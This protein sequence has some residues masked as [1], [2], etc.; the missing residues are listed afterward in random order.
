MW[1]IGEHIAHDKYVCIWISMS[2]NRSVFE[3]A[4]CIQVFMCLPV[5][6]SV[7]YV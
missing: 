3:C 5:C 2:T 1:D 4:W 6:M 7:V